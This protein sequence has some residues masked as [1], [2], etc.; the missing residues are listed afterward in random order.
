MNYQIKIIDVMHIVLKLLCGVF[1][2]ICTFSNTPVVYTTYN[3]H[4][5]NHLQMDSWDIIEKQSTQEP[6][7]T[8]KPSIIKRKIHDT[9]PKGINLLLLVDNSLSMDNDDH[10]KRKIIIYDIL[11]TLITHGKITKITHLFGMALFARNIVAFIELQPMN[12]QSRTEALTML[13]NNKTQKYT[14]FLPPLTFAE[15]QFYKDKLSNNNNVDVLLV[16]TDGKY[17]V[18]TAINDEDQ[19]K[20][21]IS[22]ILDN[23]ENKKI[24]TY[25]F[26]FEKNNQKKYSSQWKIWLG[27]NL[28]FFNHATQDL[29]NIIIFLEIISKHLNNYY[30]SVNR[31]MT[32]T[33]SKKHIDQ[34]NTESIS[35][36]DEKTKNQNQ[37]DNRQYNIIIFSIVFFI[38][39]LIAFILRKN[40]TLNQ[41]MLKKTND[42][43]KDLLEANNQ[44]E[45]E[46][47]NVSKKI[48]E[49]IINSIETLHLQNQKQ[50]TETFVIMIK[51]ITKNIHSKDTLPDTIQKYLLQN[52][53]SKRDSFILKSYSNALK[54]VLSKDQKCLMVF[55]NII[56]S[57][58]GK[59]TM[60]VLSEKGSIE[61]IKCSSVNKEKFESIEQIIQLINDIIDIGYQELIDTIHKKYNNQWLERYNIYNYDI[62]NECQNI[63]HTIMNLVNFPV[64]HHNFNSEVFS[65]TALCLFPDL[66]KFLKTHF[67]ILKNLQAIDRLM[68]GIVHNKRM[69]KLN[70]MERNICK[71]IADSWKNRIIEINSRKHELT[72]S[73][74]VIIKFGPKIQ[75]KELDA[76]ENTYTF[77]IVNNMKI[78]IFNIQIDLSINIPAATITTDNNEKK[79]LE[80][81]ERCFKTFHCDNVRE[82]FT[83]QV[84]L[85]FSHWFQEN[86]KKTNCFTYKAMPYKMSP[87]IRTNNPYFYKKPI[88]LEPETIFQSERIKDCLNIFE[89]ELKKEDSQIINLCGL[90]GTGKTSFI[91]HLVS[92]K[93]II[94]KFPVIMDKSYYRNSMPPSSIEKEAYKI[95]RNSL[96]SSIEINQQY[97]DFNFKN[98]TDKSIISILIKELNQNNNEFIYIIDDVHEL[99]E[100][101]YQTMVNI[102]HDL[103][104]KLIVISNW[105][106]MTPQMTNSLIKFNLISSESDEVEKLIQYSE[107]VLNYSP[108][109]MS[110]FRTV[111]GGHPKLT[112]MIFHQLHD[113]CCNNNNLNVYLPTIQSVVYELLSINSKREMIKA[114]FNAIP[115]NE[116]ELLVNFVRDKRICSH[117]LQFRKDQNDDITKEQMLLFENLEKMKILKTNNFGW[118]LNIGFFKLLI[119]SELLAQEMENINETFNSDNELADK[120][121]VD[122]VFSYNLKDYLEAKRLKTEFESNNISV[123]MSPEDSITGEKWKEVYH[124][125][126]MNSTYG[127]IIIGKNGIGQYM[128][129]EL[130]LF[131]YCKHLKIVPIIASKLSNRK[132]SECRKELNKREFAQIPENNIHS[133][134]DLLQKIIQDINS[135]KK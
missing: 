15:N 74:N 68:V 39:L 67:S 59:R 25:M 75:Y 41:I 36:S 43:E 63:Y 125:K 22:N 121:H 19:Y 122:V 24:I 57:K 82:S 9:K 124:S 119:E 89:L 111:T 28:Y 88:P 91:N 110:F 134:P 46:E 45:K 106:E 116:R 83:I 132:L 81:G 56:H 60:I 55:K 97:S 103:K 21:E 99:D 49:G 23:L 112:M 64:S 66:Y 3:S 113:D 12:E 77:I 95:I 34:S 35:N 115:E 71:A 118:R 128:K 5:D 109:A 131:S 11:S 44:L 58:F 7:A 6:D 4:I 72:E 37:S 14:D 85:T 27:D 61:V 94:K 104:F 47:Y 29:Q 26:M 114:I 123:F 98:Q 117:T 86:I 76:K 108:Q 80:P 54:Y 38:S 32:D 16:I 129:E 10:D 105:F 90:K 87:S 52:K 133:N 1:I 2:L 102:A 42:I 100:N 127:A 13:L 79:F 51:S 48:A 92:E 130:I 50:A 73:G 107:P 31:N 135:N 8:L 65:K 20:K 33:I 78:Q 40:N 93:K 30:P 120:E 17:D 101:I 18:T 69:N 126:V 84:D 70:V 96:K 62:N 53:N